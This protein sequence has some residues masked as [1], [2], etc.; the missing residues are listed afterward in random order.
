MA[1][2]ALWFY[3]KDHP[4]SM[5]CM[6]AIDTCERIRTEIIY[7]AFGEAVED[8]TFTEVDGFLSLDKD[9]QWRKFLKYDYFYFI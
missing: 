2:R 5:E 3:L 7:K 1:I 8:P 9:D 4:E 6:P